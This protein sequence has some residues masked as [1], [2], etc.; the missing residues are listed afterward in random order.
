MGGMFSVLKVRKDQKPGDY[1]NPGWY[2]P[3]AGTRAFEWTGGALPNPAR[4]QAS[5]ATPA[6]GASGAA[7][8]QTEVQIRKPS[9]HSGH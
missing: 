8:A 7:G 1:K 2:T 6:A 3:P 5:P 4:M 9:G